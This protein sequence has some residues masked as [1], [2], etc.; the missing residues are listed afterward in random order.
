M[1]QEHLAAHPPVFSPMSSLLTSFC[2]RLRSCRR[3]SG[4]RLPNERAR[5]A[6]PVWR[7]IPPK[8]AFYGFG[9]KP[10]KWIASVADDL[11]AIESPRNLA[12]QLS[13]HRDDDLCPC[14]RPHQSDEGFPCF[15]QRIRAVVTGTSCPASKRSFKCG[16]F[17]FCF[18]II[19]RTVCVWL[20]RCTMRRS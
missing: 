12:D 17:L 5:R 13:L 10:S 19:R 4:Q 6:F 15:A 3:H 8:R 7:S 9:D 2:G 14:A 18:S 1:L 20:D 11:P 16:R